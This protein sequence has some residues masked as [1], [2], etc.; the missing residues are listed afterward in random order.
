MLDL[1]IKNGFLITMEGSGVG[2]V[3]NGA[4]GIR[5]NSIEVVGETSDVC[6]NYDAHRVIDAS[7]KAVLPGFIDA[8]IHTSIG[9]L[10]GIS[11]DI[12]NW[13]VDGLW[14]FETKL[15]LDSS[16]KMSAIGSRLTIL[17][18]VKAGTTTFCDFDTPMD[19]LVRCH[20]EMG[21]RAQVAE[22]VSGLPKH[23]DNVR[24]D[25]P[26]E[27]D[28]TIEEEKLHRNIRLIETYHGAADGRITCLFGPQAADMVSREMLLE[29]KELAKKY[30]VGIH[31]HVSQSP[32]ENDQTMRRY[33]L[34][35]IPFLNEIGYLDE[36]LLAVHLVDATDDEV[37]LLA[38]KGAAMIAC[39]AG[40][41]MLGGCIPPSAEFLQCSDRLAIGSDEAPGNNCCNMFNEMKFTS[42]INKCKL[43]SYTA[44]PAWKVLR[45]ATID[46]ARAIGLGDSIGS[47]TAGKKADVILVDLNQPTMQ[48]VITYPLRNVVP[49]L[50]YSARGPEVETVIIDGKIV[51]DHFKMQTVDEARILQEATEA[52]KIICEQAAPEF[53]TRKT[54][55][56]HMMRNEQM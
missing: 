25:A 29:I 20:M 24:A 18:A 43:H 46:G 26:F 41:A 5:G 42:L 45:M 31:M 28:S 51:V 40:S 44:F 13:M 49:N 3:E 50:V 37:R 22:L 23:N 52:A 32:H 9:V 47:L 35:A 48:P 34:R 53:N 2:V 8:H 11:Q 12:D 17:E 16:G 10:R 15:R 54:S 55:L 56:Y 38:R 19:V 33:G 1:L 4:V 30:G 39:N 7:S 27:L 6:K 21:T 36:S 14:P